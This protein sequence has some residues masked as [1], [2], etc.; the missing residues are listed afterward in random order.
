[1]AFANETLAL[2]SLSYLCSGLL[3]LDSAELIS[4]IKY[5]IL[6]GNYRLL[7]YVTWY[8]VR[9]TVTAIRD[10]PRNSEDSKLHTLN[11]LISRAASEA[12]NYDFGPD[13][14][15]LKPKL[16]NVSLDCL[17]QN[18]RDVLGAAYRFRV[19]ERQPDWTMANGNE[20]PIYPRTHRESGHA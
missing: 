20:S 6:A 7:A 18:S 12:G 2:S 11:G 8:W 4:Y 13:E 3:D 10:M 16:E 15:S 9:L 1:M 5:N 14:A 17:S 19:D